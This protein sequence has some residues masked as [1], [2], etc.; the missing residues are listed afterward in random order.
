MTLSSSG[1]LFQLH[2]VP[3]LVCAASCCACTGGKK[4]AAAEAPA[5]R[6]RGRPQKQAEESEEEEEEEQEDEDEEAPPAK[7]VRVT[8]RELGRVCC[9]KL[10]R[11][12]DR[13]CCR[14]A[15]LTCVQASELRIAHS[16]WH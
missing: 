6:G 9:E 12:G 16:G 15:C 2:L 3:M 1:C 10:G 11:R 14:A 8:L 7:K 5:K 4:A 13:F